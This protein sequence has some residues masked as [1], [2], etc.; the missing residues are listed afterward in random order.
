MRPAR[1]P[2]AARLRLAV[3]GAAPIALEA[4]PRW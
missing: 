2:L 3:Y 1:E 4:M